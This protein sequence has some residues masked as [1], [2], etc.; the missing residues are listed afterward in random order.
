LVLSLSKYALFF[1]SDYGFPYS[2]KF[3]FERWQKT[4]LLVFFR[5]G[6]CVGKKPNV[7][8]VRLAYLVQISMVFT[9]FRIMH[10]VVVYDLLRGSST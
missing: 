5:V 1:I 8:F 10:N 6:L 2:V 9:I 3:L 7:L 4:A